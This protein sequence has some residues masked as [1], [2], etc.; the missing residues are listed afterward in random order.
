MDIK[1]ITHVMFHNFFLIFGGSVIVMYVHHLIFGNDSINTH[2]ITALFIATVLCSLAQF[3]FYAKKQLSQRQ[4]LVRQIIHLATILAIILSTAY[5]ME[6]IGWER[7][8]VI[9]LFVG[10]VVVMYVSVTVVSMRRSKKLADVLNQ[11][12]KERFKE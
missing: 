11:K 6:W 8:I 3:I 9:L 1:E 4:M 5:F 10:Y 12:L 2:D 7:P